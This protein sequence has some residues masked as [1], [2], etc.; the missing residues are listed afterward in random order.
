VVVLCSSLKRAREIDNLGDRSGQDLFFH[1]EW[2]ESAEELD[3]LIQMA[4]LFI[5][6]KR[7]IASRRNLELAAGKVPVFIL[8]RR[9]GRFYL[10]GASDDEFVNASISQ[11]FSLLPNVEVEAGIPN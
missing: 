11:V 6:P 10:P 5:V 3:K 8:A 2:T 4:K 9:E 7:F 1:G